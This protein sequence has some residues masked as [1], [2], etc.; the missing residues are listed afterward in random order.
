MNTQT[1]IEV[2]PILVIIGLFWWMI[3]SIWNE[4]QSSHSKK[5]NDHGSTLPFGGAMTVAVADGV[6]TSPAASEQPVAA[7][8]MSGLA[9]IR[10]IDKLF[11][12][13]AFLNS[14]RLVYETVVI[15]FARGDR[16]VLQ[17]LL[18][19]D[20]YEV[21][22]QVIRG[23]ETRGEHQDCELVCIQD[24][25]IDRITFVDH[26]AE[27]TVNFSGL[28]VVATRDADGTVIDGN[29]QRVTTMSDA[30]TFARD[31]TAAQSGWMIIATDTP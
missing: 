20:V 27:I 5:S 13:E 30:W 22:D 7:G 18:S 3:C 6:A 21:F 14:G 11:D 2:L 31:F 26:R 8:A 16:D 17:H 28:F 10:A 9:A 23:R 12:V 29:P 19:A 1:D 15:A 24:A 25:D 4:I